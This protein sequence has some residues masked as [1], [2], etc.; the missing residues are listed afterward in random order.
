M[1]PV[2]IWAE[3]TSELLTPM[4]DLDCKDL[5][6][7]PYPPPHNGKHLCQVISKSV[8]ACRNFAPDK[9]FSMT[10]KCDLD[11]CP[12]DASHNGVHFYEVS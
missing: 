11:L 1:V 4:C 10:S 12:R 6:F 5:D 7:A 3:F 8:Y 9:C 2:H